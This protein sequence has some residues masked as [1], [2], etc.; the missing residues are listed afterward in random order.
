MQVKGKR[1]DTDTGVR[2][3]A[4]ARSQAEQWSS[5]ALPLKIAMLLTDAYIE[6]TTQGGW[7]GPLR[8]GRR[9]T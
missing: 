6:A 9:G 7:G 4:R 2:T 8:A 1:V 5:A 3:R